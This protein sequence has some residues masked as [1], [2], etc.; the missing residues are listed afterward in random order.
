[1]DLMNRVFYEI[2]DKFALVFKYDILVYS[3]NEEDH[4]K[5]LR[6]VL[7]TLRD[8]QLYAKFSKCEFWLENV[9]FLRH[10]V[11]KEGVALDPA[12]IIVV[13]EWPTPKSFTNIRSFL[14][15]ARYY[16]RFVRYF[17]RIDKPMT[18]LMN[19]EARF[20]WNKHCEEVFQALKT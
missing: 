7:N 19:N 17:S 14:G 5:Y 16:R 18:T 8:N 9:V 13:S 20:E 15:L 11:C 6:Y 4:A 10:F 1:M 12:K 3:R 2:L